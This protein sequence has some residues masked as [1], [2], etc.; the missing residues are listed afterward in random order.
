LAQNSADDFCVLATLEEIFAIVIQ[1]DIIVDRSVELSESIKPLFLE[2]ATD[3][4]TDQR[5]LL[6]CM[7]LHFNRTNMIDRSRKLHNF[8]FH[9]RTSSDINTRDIIQRCIT[10]AG[11]ELS[12]QDVDNAIVSPDSLSYLMAILTKSTAGDL[13][14]VQVC[15]QEI[16]V[17][18]RSLLGLLPNHGS[19]G[20]F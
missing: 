17:Y 14:K 20:E 9:E 10:A 11:I 16:R 7:R 18:I 3:L 12:M 1:P 19:R 2:A 8:F 6:G 5:L 4:T 15:G 13:R